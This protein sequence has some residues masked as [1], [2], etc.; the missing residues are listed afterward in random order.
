MPKFHKA[1]VKAVVKSTQKKCKSCKQHKSKSAFLCEKGKP[2]E[3][4]IIC[5]TTEKKCSSCDMV[6]YLKD[7]YYAKTGKNNKRG[8]CIVCYRAKTKAIVDSYRLL[9][10]PSPFDKK[11]CKTCKM[12]KE[13]REYRHNRSLKGKY[14]STC[15][16]CE[17][18]E[19]AEKMKNPVF[20]MFHNQYNTLHDQFRSLRGGEL[21]T[22]FIRVGE[23]YETQILGVDFVIYL[24]V[25]SDLQGRYYKI[26]DED[27]SLDLIIPYSVF[28]EVGTE[29]AFIVCFSFLNCQ[30]LKK[31]EN[32]GK[33]NK[34]PK[35][36]DVHAHI[37]TMIQILKDEKCGRDYDEMLCRQYDGRIPYGCVKWW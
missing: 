21:W 30:L 16:E 34:V 25:L 7:F 10:E 4:C 33:H 22:K 3:N 14:K 29:E 35:D 32:I 15:L 12:E 17:G 26:T 31:G 5:E 23:D 2:L 20:A 18:N 13:L 28:L 24:E 6:K 1:A 8:D 9:P 19:L 11:V 27:M 36:F 37:K